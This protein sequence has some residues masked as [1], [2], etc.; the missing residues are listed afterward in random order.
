MS[1]FL[2]RFRHNG[3]DCSFAMP[4][5]SWADAEARLRSMASSAR[6]QGSNASAIPVNAITLPF[7][8]VLARFIVWW[9]NL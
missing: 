7:A 9:R 2:I 4:A 6:V 1:M 8:G 5:N 3:D